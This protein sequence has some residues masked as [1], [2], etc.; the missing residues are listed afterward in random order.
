MSNFQ[1][2]SSSNAK[3]ILIVGD[4]LGDNDKLVNLLYHQKFSHT[5]I[6]V[7]TGNIVDFDNVS[8][9]K[10]LSFFNGVRNA[11]SVK[12]Q[13]EVELLQSVANGSSETW[14]K[15]FEKIGNLVDFVTNMPSIICVRDDIYVVS[16]GVEP[17]KTIEQQY[18]DVYYSIG[19]YDAD[20][21]YYQ[22]ENPEEK[23]WYGYKFSSDTADIHVAFGTL[24][25]ENVIQ[26][27]GWCL[28]RKK[29]QPL[30]CL[31]VPNTKDAKVVYTQSI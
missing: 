4:I 30:N 21:K 25:L 26:N 22:F 16:A 12:G 18:D 23:S 29:G 28:G 15:D 11:Y 14:V 13:K 31:I 24:H 2:L 20:S 19:E 3:R 10:V 27:A 6:L 1:N 8:S 9:L 7:A 5:D 17:H